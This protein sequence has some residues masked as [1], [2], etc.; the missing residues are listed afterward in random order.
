MLR[1]NTVAFWSRG[2]FWGGWVLL[3]GGW[4]ACVTFS[5]DVRVQSR[6]DRLEASALPGLY[7]MP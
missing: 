7:Y 6:H 3:F 2:G 4:S 5:G 1:V